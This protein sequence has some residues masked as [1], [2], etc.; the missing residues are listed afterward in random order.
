M[1][2]VDIAMVGELGADALAGVAI[3][4]SVFFACTSVAMGL[5]MA[6]DPLISQAFGADRIDDVGMWFWQGVW[7]SLIAGLVLPVLFYDTEALMLWLG[8]APQVADLGSQYVCVRGLSVAPFLLFTALRSLLNGGNQTRPVMIAAVLMNAV[9]FVLDYGLVSGRLGMPVLGVRGAAVATTVVMWALC[10]ALALYLWTGRFGVAIGT[11][12]R[13]QWRLLAEIGRLG[14]PIG[15]QMLAEFGVFAAAGVFAGQ[16]S[17]VALAAH[18][19][20][21]GLASLNYMV[22]LGLSIAAGVR[23]GRYVGA[24][25]LDGAL[26]AGKVAIGSGALIMFSCSAVFLL[27]PR[28][29]CQWFTADAEVL[30]IAE[31]LVLIAAGFQIFDGLQCVAGGC[32][33]GAGDTRAAFFANV[34]AHWLGG[35]PLGWSLAFAL[36]FG[37]WGLWWGLAAS[38]GFAAVLLVARFFRKSWQHS[39]PEAVKA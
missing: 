3:G 14:F 8:Q 25:D 18:Q 21:L 16:L 5:V 4:N 20:A 9:N 32:L 30:A 39:V 36:G 35:L 38:L 26:L 23:V 13:P 7:C 34:V 29:L 24:N 27:A 33:R 12:R 1:G 11:P 17:A 31:S 28:W 15:G 10:A 6:L 37:I 19:I 22:P 2:L